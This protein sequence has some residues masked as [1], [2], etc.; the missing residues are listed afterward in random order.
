M[1][2]ILIRCSI[3]AV[4]ILFCYAIVLAVIAFR[5]PWNGVEHYCDWVPEDV[6]RIPRYSCHF[7]AY[8]VEVESPSRLSRMFLRRA[9]GHDSTASVSPSNPFGQT[10][11]AVHVGFPMMRMLTLTHDVPWTGDGWLEEPDAKVH[12]CLGGFD[13]S[14][15]HPKDHWRRNIHALSIQGLSSPE[16]NVNGLLRAAAASFVLALVLWM[17]FARLLRSLIARYRTRRGLCA[18]CR[19]PVAPNA[20]CCPECGRAYF[21]SAQ[22]EHTAPTS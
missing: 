4:G 16:L 17:L 10:R 2:R 5:Q 18:A 13:Q 21:A 1:V 6:S 22:S 7:P 9:T 8:S 15:F 3:L 14:G 12:L 20:T 11:C 19:Y